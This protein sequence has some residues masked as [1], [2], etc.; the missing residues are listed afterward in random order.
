MI[1]KH[2]SIQVVGRGT[3]ITFSISDNVGLNTVINDLTSYLNQN[4]SWFVDGT[5][6]INVGKR[7]FN[8]S[9][10]KAIQGTINNNSGLHILKFSA[11]SAE[12]G[13]LPSDKISTELEITT[14]RSN[15]LLNNNLFPNY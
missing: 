13:L 1:T 10:L 12:V 6:D 4:R 3:Q 7:I 5:I 11:K 9:D 2:E 8:S 14:E 15:D